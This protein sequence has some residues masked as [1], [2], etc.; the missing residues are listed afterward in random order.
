MTPTSDD[1]FPDSIAVPDRSTR[2]TKRK[3]GASSDVSDG[4]LT[5]PA[6]KK[7]GPKPKVK[8]AADVEDSGTESEPKPPKK[9]SGPKPQPKAKAK[10][11]PK[12]K[13]S[14]KNTSSDDEDIEVVKP[15][16]EQSKI[17]FIV[18]EA[19]TEGSQRLSLKSVTSFD[20]AIEI[21]HETIGCVSV[22]RKPMLTYKFSTA[23]KN[24][25]TINLRTEDDW[26]GL[27]SDVLAKMKTKKDISVNIFVL[28]ENYMLSLRAKNKQQTTSTKGK[29]KIRKLT[30]MD[31]DNNE[32]EGEGDDEQ[33]VA[34]GEKGAL[35]ELETEYRKCV[36]CGPTVM[37]KIDRSGN[38][39][40]LTF[41]QR[42][43][44]AVSLA[45]GTIKV[46]KITPPKGD[47]FSMFHGDA[48]AP[49]P[50]PPPPPVPA[51][52]PQWFPQMP[53]IGYGL[54]GFHPAYPQMPAPAPPARPH[55][56][57][58][59]SDPPDDADA[60]PSI[61]EFIETLIAKVP[62]REALRNAGTILHS[63]HYFGID[64]ITTLTADEMGTDNFGNV[65]RGDAEYLLGQARK[66]V[67]RLDKLARRARL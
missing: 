42:H 13:K 11:G 63:L 20:D 18:P 50:P 66:E 53:P 40:H 22:E 59:S 46:T 2:S 15:T 16:P 27:V 49:T 29:G 33:D 7:P 45:C 32:S 5:P 25:T 48:K 8:P 26:D 12:P 23:N 39:V 9:K 30:V 6:K 64:E 34:A 60:Y 47:L 1:E 56:A 24:A 19:A 35:S 36:R 37:C 51:Q 65:L 43:A 61:L 57:V 14:K 3:S 44:W 52:Y 41:P 54:P 38:H 62:Q 55:H 4:D 58:M 21:M 17:I 67:K 28:P 31:L 10:P